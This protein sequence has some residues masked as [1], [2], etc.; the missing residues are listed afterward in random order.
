MA[1][2]GRFAIAFARVCARAFVRTTA[3]VIARTT[4]CACVVAFVRAAV[5]ATVIVF[6]VA[7]TTACACAIAT[8]RA[9]VRS[10]LAAASAPAHPD[11]AIAHPDSVRVIVRARVIVI[12]RARAA[13]PAC[14]A[15]PARPCRYPTLAGTPASPCH[16]MSSVRLLISVQLLAG[17][18]QCPRFPVSPV[19]VRI[20]SNDS[21]CFICF[22]RFLRLF[23]LI[24]PIV[25]V[26]VCFPSASC[27][28]SVWLSFGSRLV[29]VWSPSDTISSH[30]VPLRLF[31]PSHSNP[32]QSAPIV[33]LF[34]FN[35][36]PVRSNPP[37]IRPIR[38]HLPP[39]SASI[40]A[41]R[42][43]PLCPRADVYPPVS[44]RRVD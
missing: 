44:C 32:L 33:H 4:A 20:C 29:L 12:V 9:S 24:A 18:V 35:R 28:I 40:P 30:P 6:A 38:P 11:F 31:R 13:V 3:Y 42:T 21:V 25:P 26:P 17:P 34:H 19:S 39:V 22:T 10:R 5:L 43:I 36:P 41:P 15:A 8:A 7:R 14:A 2:M 1:C 16:A 23:R 37:S 27:L